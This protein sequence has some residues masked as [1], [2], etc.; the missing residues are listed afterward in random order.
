MYGWT[1]NGE[2]VLFRSLRDAN[3]GSVLT[4]L[5]TVGVDCALSDKLIMLTAGAGDFSPNGQRIVYSP[6]F[7]DFRTWKRYEG[8]WAQNLLIFDLQR[9]D[10]Q[11]IATSKRTERDP[12]W[13]GNQI[14]FVADRSGG[15]EWHPEPL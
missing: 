4:A 13:I 7:R 5:Y 6:L 12:M 9:Y 2:S 8:G 10:F 1:P 11:E 3:K 15:P 14:Y